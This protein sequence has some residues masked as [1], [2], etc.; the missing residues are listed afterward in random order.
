M[1]I[2]DRC[3]VIS[4][5]RNLDFN[6]DKK[7]SSFSFPKVAIAI[8]VVVL[9]DAPHRRRRRRLFRERRRRRRTHTLAAFRRRVVVSRNIKE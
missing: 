8:A 4:S 6:S 1:C 2:R 7:A 9:D 3:G 5:T